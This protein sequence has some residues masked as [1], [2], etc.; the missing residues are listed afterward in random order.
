MFESLSIQSTIFEGL[1]ENRLQTSLK[2]QRV[3]SYRVYNVRIDS[4]VSQGV[5]NRQTRVEWSTI[6]LRCKR[7]QTEA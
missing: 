6:R 2:V 3:K 1:T 4:I 7:G 5:V